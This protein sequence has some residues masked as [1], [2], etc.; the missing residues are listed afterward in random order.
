MKLSY[1]KLSSCPTWHWKPVSL[2]FN[3]FWLFTRLLKN[4]HAAN[5]LED[6]KHSLMKSQTLRQLCVDALIFIRAIF[7]WPWNDF[8]RTKQKQPANRNETCAFGWFSISG[9]KKN[10][11]KSNFPQIWATE[12]ILGISFLSY[13]LRP[14]FWPFFKVSG[15]SLCCYWS[16]KFD[17]IRIFLA[18][19]RKVLC[20]PKI[21]W[22]KFV[23]S[24][25]LFE[26]VLT[27]MSSVSYLFC[28]EL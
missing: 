28:S 2:F 9:W 26:T 25:F 3:Q 24:Q 14:R 12:T 19:I 11:L 6:P 15:K 16:D 23:R 10:S 4:V 22:G 8:A 21:Q 17:F 13:G 18:L 1:L 5:F 7:V 27:R 20:K